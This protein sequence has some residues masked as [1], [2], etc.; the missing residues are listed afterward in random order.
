[1]C[2]LFRDPYAISHI[3]ILVKAKFVASQLFYNFIWA[4]VNAPVG[5]LHTVTSAFLLCISL[6][7]ALCIAVVY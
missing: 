5:L 2:I 3:S 4:G 1:M 6:V 7:L